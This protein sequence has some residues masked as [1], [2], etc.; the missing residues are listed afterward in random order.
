MY[1][2]PSW[3]G[4][5]GQVLCTGVISLPAPHLIRIMIYFAQ[6]SHPLLTNGLAIIGIH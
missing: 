2:I 5:Y 3:V 4:W 1:Q 6:K